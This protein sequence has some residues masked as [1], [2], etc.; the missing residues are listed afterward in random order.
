MPV[1]WGKGKEDTGTRKRPPTTQ[2]VSMLSLAEAP[3]STRKGLGVRT[4]S[5]RA[6]LRPRRLRLPI[7][8][9]SCSL[10]VWRPSRMPPTLSVSCPVPSRPCKRLA[11]LVK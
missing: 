5:P 2:N 6:S 3:A 7:P 8:H 4:P 10:V 9:V 11:K 1:L